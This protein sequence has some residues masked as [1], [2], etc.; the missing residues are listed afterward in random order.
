[1]RGALLAACLLLSTLAACEKNGRGGESSAAVRDSAGVRIIEN[2]GA[3]GLPDLEWKVSE[4]PILDVGDEGSDPPLY[5]ITAATRLSDGRIV[6]ASAGTKELQIYR[7]DGKLLSRVGRAGEGPGEFQTP[8][9]VGAL[10]GD[11]IAAWDAGLLRLSLF[12]PAGQF[13][14][15]VSPRAALGVFPLVVGRLDEGRFVLVTGSGTGVLDLTGKSVQ[16]DS[17]T[18]LVLEP[19]GEVHDTIGR[20]PGTEQIALGS[21]REG[22]LMRPLPFGK[23][24]VA[25]VQGG[26]VFVGTGDRYELAAYEPKR[27]LRALLRAERDPVPVTE[28]DIEGYRRELLTIGGEGDAQAKRQQDRLLA[29]APYPEKMP[30]FTRIVP[31]TEGNLW[32]QDPQKPGMRSG[33]LWTV[34]SPAGQARGT[35][36]LPDRLNVQQI[37]ADWVLGIRLDGDNVEHLQLYELTKEEPGVAT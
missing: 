6:L 2:R 24:T 33:T 37:G 32:V 12:T 28:G 5:G 34:F 8:F 27:G 35:V 20:F 30:A 16:R 21:P 31:D 19:G 17:V 10:P 15:S 25:A 14:R 4:A 11:S 7:S 36:R 22:F 13:V 1:M 23:S 29:A 3:S 9:W 26:R 18:I